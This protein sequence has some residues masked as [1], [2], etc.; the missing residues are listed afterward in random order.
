MARL[1]IGFRRRQHAKSSGPPGDPMPSLRGFAGKNAAIARDRRVACL[2]RGDVGND[3]DVMARPRPGTARTR[4]GPR[5]RANVTRSGGFPYATAKQ[6]RHWW[7]CRGMVWVAPRSG[8]DPDS[9]TQPGSLRFGDQGSKVGKSKK[10][11]IWEIC[12]IPI[13]DL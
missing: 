4:V 12:S 1:E 3:D 2:G 13:A 8:G 11:K 7:P 5:G 6:T 9:G 10:S